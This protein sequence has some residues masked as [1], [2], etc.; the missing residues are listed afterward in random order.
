[1]NKVEFKQHFDI[2]YSEMI[3]KANNDET[4]VCIKNTYSVPSSMISSY[5][6]HISG[7]LFEE[8]R[9]AFF[10][11]DLIETRTD[12]RENVQIALDRYEVDP[13]DFD[14]EAFIQH[15]IDEATEKILETDLNTTLNEMEVY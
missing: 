1:M 4:I 8:T 15:L 6:I 10:F 9:W 5:I 14:E 12:I 13:E 2:G 11:K 3:F 7:T